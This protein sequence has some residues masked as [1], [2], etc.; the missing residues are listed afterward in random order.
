MAL[1]GRRFRRVG[2]MTLVAGLALCACES[3]PAPSPSPPV[4]P[5]SSLAATPAD[6][7]PPRTGGTIYL[8]TS[9]EEFNHVD[10]Q[11]IYTPEDFAFF[12]ATIYR[13]L[14]TYAAS[15]DSIEGTT[16]IPD[17][18]TDIGRPSDGG[19]TWAFTLRDGVTFQTGDP[20]TCE[21]IRYSVSRSFA[22]NMI[23][24]GPTYAIQ[25]LDIPPAT[26]KDT[27]DGFLS[28]YHGPF[29]STPEQ[30]AV[31]DQAVECSGDHRTITFHL[32]RPVAEFNHA[33]TLGFS[34]VMQAADTGETYGRT[35]ESRPLSSGPYMVE[36]YEPGE[37]GTFVLVRNP[38]WNAASDPIR[39]AY[40]DRW[41]IEFGVDAVDI[42]RRMVAAAGEDAFAL[43]YGPLQPESLADVFSGAETPRGEFAGRAVAGFDPY[44]RYD[45]INVERVPNLAIRQAMLVALDRGAIRDLRGGEAY[46][47]FA[48]GVIKPNVGR[49]YAPTGLWDTSFGRAI[50]D[51]GDPDLA[52]QLV[53]EAGETFP[54]LAFSAPDTPENQEAASIVIDSLGRAGFEVEFKPPCTAGY[55]CSIVL[56]DKSDFGTGGWGAEWP[57]A[58]TVIPTLF[59]KA[60]G[61]DLS[62][63]DDPAFNAAVEDA[64]GTIDGD[65][66]SAK[67]Q[68]LHEQAIDN[69][70][71]IP[72]FF[73]LQH[74][75]AGPGIGPAYLW[76]AYSSWPYAEMHI[77]R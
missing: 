75:L 64:F 55:Y 7:P 2:A 69:A 4:A 46:A 71:V 14:V 62:K 42:D 59:T 27:D 49:D 43:Q 47:A 13:S 73:S 61:W 63:V 3:R 41:V 58:S 48:D 23:S 21:D 57:S 20:I 16:L 51:S 19:R 17:L 30:Q 60:G 50:P 66:R 5:L 31:F 74:R 25:Y 40:P 37:N 35:P 53:A 77:T 18:A 68:A 56:D 10:P 11:R 36:R 15:P 67:W 38:E 44:V 54:D 8:L 9:A 65:E 45:W 70:W 33:T 28:S 1:N 76:P 26:E 72:T 32:N 6:S 24:E 39:K 22:N 12:G 52:R 34:P 29:E